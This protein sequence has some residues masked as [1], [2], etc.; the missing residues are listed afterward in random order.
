MMFDFEKEAA[1][2]RRVAAEFGKMAE[3]TCL[4]NNREFYLNMEQHWLSL[5]QKFE[6]DS[7]RARGQ[8]RLM[9]IT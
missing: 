3:K 1:A 7:K 5:A 9:G 8:P 2:C 6:R 4:T